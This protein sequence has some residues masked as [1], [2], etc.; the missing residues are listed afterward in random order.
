MKL[1]NAWYCPFGQRAWMTLVHK[2]I[3]FDY[4]EVDPYD[5]TESW[6]AISR[7]AAMVPVVIQQ[8]GDGSETTIVESNRV[9]EY[10]EDW[11]PQ[12]PIYSHLP[13]Q[14]AEQKYWMDHIG[15]NI[16]SYFYKFLNAV[17]VDQKQAYLKAKLLAGM[18]TITE[19]MDHKGPFLME[20]NCQQSILLFFPLHFE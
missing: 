7:G 18:L 3:D 17:E 9:I 2:G 6:L 16:V 8:N 13:N 4:I 20:S 14:K 11:Q 12:P 5:E 10:L 19:A 15:N 1:Y